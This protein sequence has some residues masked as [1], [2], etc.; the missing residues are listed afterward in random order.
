MTAALAQLVDH[1]E[2]P[3]ERGVSVRTCRTVLR[4]LA[5]IAG[6][7]GE[8]RW[9]CRVSKLASLCEMS[10]STIKRAE[11]YL[12]THGFL[13]R[14]QVGGGRASTRWRILVDRLSGGP[15]L[16]NTPAQRPAS[17]P[18]ANPQRVRREPAQK[19]FTSS[20]T[21]PKRS[22][23]DRSGMSPSPA[24]LCDLHDSEGGYLPDGV[25]H[26]CPACR[27]NQRIRR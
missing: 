12:V 18:S 7:D 15:E 19:P 26:R 8:F 14:A 9:G 21:W 20:W 5:R 27:R 16:S 23:G 11:R 22:R 13:E 6:P 17:P 3:A 25:T 10:A 24:V 4:T 2:L 1:V